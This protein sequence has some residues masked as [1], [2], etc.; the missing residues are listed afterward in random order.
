MFHEFSL[1]FKALHD[2]YIILYPFIIQNG[3]YLAIISTILFF[4]TQHSKNIKDH[5]YVKIYSDKNLTQYEKLIQYEKCCKYADSKFFVFKFFGIIK[6]ILFK[7]KNKI[8]RQKEE[9]EKI[10]NYIYLDEIDYK[11]EKHHVI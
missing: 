1:M 9:I 5:A 4:S 6:N 8:K 3:G 7:N 11:E 10:E 2:I